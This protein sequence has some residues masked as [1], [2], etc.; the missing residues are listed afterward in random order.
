MSRRWEQEQKKRLVVSDVRGEHPAVQAGVRV[1]E[2]VPPRQRRGAPAA[3]V[4][5]AALAHG[6]R[7]VVDVVK[8]E[9]LGGLEQL[10]YDD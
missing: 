8:L 4:R 2:G 1:L 9:R 6:G 5:V 3:A 7:V 10:G